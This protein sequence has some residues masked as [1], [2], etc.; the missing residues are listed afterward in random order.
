MSERTREDNIRCIVS[1]EDRICQCERCPSL[2]RCVR[3]P[4]LGKGDLEPEIVLIF[5]SNRSFTQDIDYIIGLRN[6]IKNEFK[7]E[8]I[9]HT[10]MVRC[11]PKACTVRHGVSCYTD[12]KL[13]DKENRCIL[14]GKQCE[15]I[16]IRP[17]NEEIISCLPFLLEEIDILD[18]GYFILFGE[19]VCEFVL[20]S[21]GI[22]DNIKLGNR[23]EYNNR[24]ILTTVYEED[25]GIEECKQLKELA[26][27]L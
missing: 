14:S 19:R 9:Y 16:P 12:S 27:N 3:K 17:A 5:E 10:Y 15:G 24:I 25:F 26:S 4:S 13:L 21:F 6:L 1:L 2:T 7:H 20:K 8:K 22:F 18:P 23:Y 11:Q